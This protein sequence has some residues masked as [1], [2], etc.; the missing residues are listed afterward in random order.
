MLTKS[1]KLI[2]RIKF[3]YQ[4]HLH[5]WRDQQT[6]LLWYVEH[7]KSSES[8]EKLGQEYLGMSE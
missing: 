1:I 4:L 7:D 3:T 5:C 8:C 6:T 2:L